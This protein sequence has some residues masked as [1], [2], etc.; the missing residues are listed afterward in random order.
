M[1]FD[2]KK[3][4][5]RDAFFFVLALLDRWFF[6]VVG[7]WNSQQLYI[8]LHSLWHSWFRANRSCLLHLNAT[9]LA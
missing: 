7:H 6:I 5:G 1:I 9:C 3:K 8:S 2:K 4:N